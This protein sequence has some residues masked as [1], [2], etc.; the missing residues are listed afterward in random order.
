MEILE[1]GIQVLT[2]IFS[3][4]KSRYLEREKKEG[5]ATVG[6]DGDVLT[7]DT[8]LFLDLLG[9]LVGLM[10]QMEGKELRRPDSIAEYRKASPDR[11]NT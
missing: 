1:Q 11:R 10:F 7:F 8:V 4:Y 3:D 6:A 9:I 5:I 2:C